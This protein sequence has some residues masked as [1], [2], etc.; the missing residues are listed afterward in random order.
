MLTTVCDSVR[1]AVSSSVRC[2][3]VRHSNSCSVQQ[4]AVERIIAVSG[5]AAACAVV[6]TAVCGCPAVHAAVCGCQA[7]RSVCGSPAVS[8]F[9]NK[10]KTY[11][12]KF[13]MHQTI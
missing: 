6:C 13:G 7:M 1:C 4:F 9:S 8:I 11:L 3:D 10:F 5:S 2:A 12:Y